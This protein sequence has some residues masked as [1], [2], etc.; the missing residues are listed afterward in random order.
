MTEAQA[1]AK[2][3][4]SKITTGT[5][6]HHLLALRRAAAPF[7]ERLSVVAL[8]LNHQRRHDALAP[9]RDRHAL[10]PMPVVKA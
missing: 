9:Q 1:A 8:D 2:A 10:V 4:C 5:T 7:A 3:R 6:A